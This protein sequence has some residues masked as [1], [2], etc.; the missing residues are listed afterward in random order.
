MKFNCF[1]YV[2]QFFGF[3]PEGIRV[4]DVTVLFCMCYGMVRGADSM[5]IVKLYL[6]LVQLFDWSFLIHSVW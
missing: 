1:S 2:M 3:E 5:R 4:Y 6:S